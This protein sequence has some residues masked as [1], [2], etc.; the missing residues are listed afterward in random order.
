MPRGKI[1]QEAMLDFIN[2]KL[3][4]DATEVAELGNTRPTKGRQNMD[5]NKR[6]N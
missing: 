2:E 4:I 6:A 3:R 5:S 1:F